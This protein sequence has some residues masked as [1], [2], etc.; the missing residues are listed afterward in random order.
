MTDYERCLKW[1]CEEDAKIP[2]CLSYDGGV[3]PC[4]WIAKD[5][6]IS[7]WKV[8]R[9]MKRLEAE[10]YVVK[11]HV[12]GWDEWTGNLYCIHGYS[13]TQ[14]AADTDWWKN[15]R[16]LEEEEIRKWADQL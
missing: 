1:I 4:T 8:R 2:V 7:V 12:G 3:Y 11:D 15:K 5:L 6:G 13:I 10:G 9:I 14:K 16:K